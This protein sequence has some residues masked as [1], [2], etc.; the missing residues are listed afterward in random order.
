MSSSVWKLCLEHLQGEL[1]PQQFNTWIRPLQAEEQDAAIHLLA[2]NR[3]VKDWIQE[4]FFQEINE[5][6]RKIS[7]RQYSLTIAVGCQKKTE[8]IKERHFTTSKTVPHLSNLN[9]NFTFSSFIEGKSNQL[10]K[11]A[12]MQVAENPGNSYNPL[13]IYGDVGL[14][15][16]HL[17]HAIG[18]L[19]TRQKPKMKVVYL[20]SERFVAD[21]VK[22]LQHNTL[23][24]FKHY[25]RSIDILLIDDIQFF[26][27]KEK[28]QEEFFHTFNKM[29]EGKQQIV[30]T[31]DRYPKE[32]SGLQE[33]LK[34]RFGW[35]LTV[36]I[37][38]PETETRV[39]IIK[40]KSAS[41]NKEVP[42]NVAF[43]IADRFRANVRELEGALNRVIAT[44]NL[45]GKP[46][47]M[48]LTKEV[49]R[50]ILIIQNRLVT[51]ENIQKTTAE[52]YHIRTADL[53]SKRRKQS[54][55]RPR[56][57]AMKL[58]KELTSCSLPEIGDAFGGRSH[59]TV[60]HACKKI[61]ELQL[62]EEK[63]NEDY[64]TLTKILTV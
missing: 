19:V 8:S 23:N 18:H 4:K 15:K 43:F 6:L 49:L 33:R 17:M 55:T 5:L 47:N 60:L 20:Y 52:Y 53:L 62:R 13:F 44:S 12:S 14:G 27:N 32:V 35:G 58:S 25:Y 46:I 45:T 39:A 21:M 40:S 30:L 1:S 7:N 57:I 24:E 61:N 16:T 37:E 38:S 59:T 9:L 2:P 63:I 56:Q 50:D 34:S 22:A 11:A 54:V 26:A 28:S 41:V 36:M 48:E 10:S 42:D 29:L 3:F 31:C 51:I 64:N